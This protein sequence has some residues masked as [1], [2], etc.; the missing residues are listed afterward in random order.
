MKE[1]PR[2]RVMSYLRKPRS[3][4]E[5]GHNEQTEQLAPGEPQSVGQK[6]PLRKILMNYLK[7]D[8]K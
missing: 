7:A 1:N 4:K 2:V 3:L 8:V 6:K 5:K